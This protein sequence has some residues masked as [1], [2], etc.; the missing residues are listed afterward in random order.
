MAVNVQTSA[1][2]C[3]GFTLTELLIVVIITGMLGALAAPTLRSG[4][5]EKLELVATQVAEAIRF[6]RSEAI[7]TGEVHSVKVSHNDEAITAEKTDLTV[8]PASV[9]SVL[10]HPISRQLYEIVVDT[11]GSAMGAEI[12]NNSDVFNYAGLGDRKR[13]MFTA[14]GI[15]VFIRP[16]AGETFHLTDGQIQLQLGGINRTVVVQPYTGRVT[17]Q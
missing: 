9:E 7:R 6:A 15:P 17:I 5:P 4:D 10:R 2:R 8:Q 3:R 13:L 1:N 14:Q 12:T 16:I 11:A